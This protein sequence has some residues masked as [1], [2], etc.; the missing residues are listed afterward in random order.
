MSETAPLETFTHKGVEIRIEYDD[1]PEHANPREGGNIG[2]MLAEGHRSYTLGDEPF[3][4]EVPDYDTAA[5]ALQHFAERGRPSLFPRWLKVYGGATVVLPL[6]L[7]DHSGLSMSTGRSMSDPGGWD[8]GVVGFIFDTPHTREETGCDPARIEAELV[9]EVA[10]YS[11]Y[12]EHQVVG[13]VAEI[14][15]DAEACWGY[16]LGDYER[17]LENVRS[18]AKATAEVM[19]KAYRKAKKARKA[20]KR[21]AKALADAHR[22]VAVL[23]IEVLQ[24]SWANEVDG[25]PE[26]ELSGG[27]I[28]ALRA[29]PPA[30]VRQALEDS[31]G[32]FFWTEMHSVMDAATA[33]L[34][35][36]LPAS[37][38]DDPEES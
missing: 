3:R 32:D 35:G 30:T 37:T 24:E 21:A 5:R 29:L 33:H 18:E 25:D 20:A 26:S 23:D 11:A 8:S 34:I 6:W 36:I 12:L 2:V 15:G 17:D 19:A 4:R 10:Y 28:E 38:F 7:L 27:V 31:V 14:G 16:V 9:S 22:P 13:W 1:T